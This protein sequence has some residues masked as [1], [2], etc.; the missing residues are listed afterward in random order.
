MN[1]IK[2]NFFEEISSSKPLFILEMAN[3]HMGDV[4]H[5]LKIIREFAKVTKKYNFR[6]AFKFQFRDM[7]SF[8]HPDYKKR[9]DIKYVKRFLETNLSEEDFKKLKNELKKHH[10]ISI[11]TP[12]DEKSVDKIEEL[13]FDI[14]KIA[15]CSFTDWPLLER[16]VK[17]S[18]PIIASTAGTELIDIDNVVNFLQN[19]NKNFALMHCVGEYPTKEKDLQLNQIEL[20]KNRYKNVTIGFSTHEEPDNFLPVQMAI[21]KGAKI[22]ERHVAVKTEKYEINAYSSTPEQIEK[23]LDSA[24]RAVKISGVSNKRSSHS[25]KEMADLKQFKRGVFAKQNIKKGELITSTNVFYAFPNTDKQLLANDLSKYNLFYATKD[26]KKNEPVI[27]VK[28]TKERE[29]IYTI[30][31][32]IGKII[33]E[34]NVIIPEKVDLEISHHYGIEK[35][36]KFGLT[37]ITVVNRDYCKKLLIMLPGQFHPIQY[38]NKKE[39]TF[40]F[41]FGEFDVTLDKKNFKC[42]PGDVITVKPGVRHSFSTKTGGILEEISSTHYINDS[43]YLDKKISD[44]KNRKTFVTYWRI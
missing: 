6:F 26:I 16:I 18:K 17:T 9:T 30:V 41:L 21:S 1:K 37:M 29:K 5:G 25:E 38:H 28:L 4:N 42:K 8:I 11:C 39:E 14:I 15:S 7:N 40:H 36:N 10:F 12:F 23:W 19:R 32:S 27:N 44:N 20:F 3:N 34:S 13:D 31:T 33:R 24:E 2:N 43:F 22:L 35:F